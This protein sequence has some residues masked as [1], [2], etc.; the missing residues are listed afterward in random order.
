MKVFALARSHGSWLAAILLIPA[1]LAGCTFQG[2]DNPVARKL[3]WFDYVDGGDIRRSCAP[4]S[5]LR[6]RFVFNASYEEQVR[7]YDF[8]DI[9]Q[10]GV[11]KARV[12]GAADLSSLSVGKAGDL[13]DPW[14]GALVT[15]PLSVEDL[16][17]LHTSM[18]ADGVYDAAPKGLEL[19]SHS[20]YWTVASCR[21]G[22]FHFNAFLW[23]SEDF[24]ALRFP[25]LLFGWDTTGV[26]VN[27]PRPTTEDDNRTGRPQ[28]ARILFRLKV[29][30]NGLAGL[31][32]LKW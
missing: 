17:R 29:G 5:P 15:V 16:G 21:S 30:D 12:F 11:L 22:Q 27:P 28:E 23:P 3:T 31:R 26:A 13:L 4:G 19:P 6:Y 2:G 7:T 20:F 32:P 25:D 8:D 9:T 10:G 1:L 24:T 18:I 14:R